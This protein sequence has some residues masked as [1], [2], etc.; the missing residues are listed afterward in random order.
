MEILEI[1]DIVWTGQYILSSILVVKQG[2]NE[3]T[4]NVS[5]PWMINFKLQIIPVVSIACNTSKVVAI[6]RR[7][8]ENPV[9]SSKMSP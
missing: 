4:T 9:P 7:M 5:F 8:H 2:P 3:I 6:R 1:H